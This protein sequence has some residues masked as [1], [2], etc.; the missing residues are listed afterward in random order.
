[1]KGRAGPLPA[2]STGSDRRALFHIL[3]ESKSKLNH[4]DCEEQRVRERVWPAE[5]AGAHPEVTD[6]KLS[7]CLSSGDKVGLSRSG[8]W[9]NLENY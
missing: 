2:M 3:G 8:S 1:M 4:S 5:R 6:A 7:G 9:K